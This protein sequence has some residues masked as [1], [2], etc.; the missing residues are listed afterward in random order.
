[1]INEKNLITEILVPG[2][3]GRSFEVQKGQYLQII[4]VEGQQV[5]DFYAF[6][7]QNHQERLSP[8]HTR[9]SLRSL[10]IKVGDLLRSSLRNPMFEVIEDTA[11]SHD[12]LIAACDEQ[13]YLVDYGVSDHR[14]CVANFEEVLQPYGISRDMFPEPFNIFQSTL[15]E[16]DGTLVQQTS[17]TKAGEYILM[18]AQMDVIGAVSACPMDLN[19]IGGSK[20]SDIMVR[21]YDQ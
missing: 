6:N 8:P 17:P 18:K 11:Q 10:T 1:M 5:A 2:G 7:S 12:L 4:D 16:P 21:I 3:H 14:S 9:T 15:I 13:R 19:L 20:I